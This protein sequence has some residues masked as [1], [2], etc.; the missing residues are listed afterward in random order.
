MKLR[1]RLFILILLFSLLPLF[2]CGSIGAQISAISDAVVDY[3]DYYIEVR[4]LSSQVRGQANLQNAE[5]ETLDYTITVDI[6]DYTALDLSSVPYTL[7]APDFSPRSIA[8]YQTRA[9][10]ALRQALE[11][12]APVGNVSAYLQIPVDFSLTQTADGWSAALSSQSKFSIRQTVEGMVSSILARNEIYQENLRK[13]LV[14]SLLQNL[15]SGAFGS[16]A[17]TDQ[18]AVTDVSKT[19][20]GSYT[21][22]FTFP[23][24]AFVFSALGETYA[25]SFNQ[26]FF[27]D[28]LAVTLPI[29]G[30]REL[31]LT[32]A[33]QLSGSVSVSLDDATGVGALLDDGGLAA[34]IAR[35]KTNAETSVAERVN[36]AWRVPP[37][38]PPASGSIMEG[39]SKGNVVEFRTDRSLGTYY[40]IRFYRIDGEDVSQDGTLTVG[41]FINGGKSA[42]LRLPGGH[43]RVVW[44]IGENWYGLKYLF[45][46]DGKI[47]NGSNAIL[48]EPGVQNIYSFK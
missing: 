30:I 41:I 20:D 29:D 25:A 31:D 18:L 21:V 28:A 39:T 16:S 15:L 8:A 24:P 37:Q 4:D 11:T 36:A 45:G 1:T 42:H 7:P 5:L 48:S 6:P 43:Y 17:Y 34:A 19:A 9:A 40:Y 44:V 23:D 33:P 27:G 47:Y 38:D 12:Y 22:S 46:T 10:L 2:G 13:M 32:G 26:P 3:S 35:E 14:A